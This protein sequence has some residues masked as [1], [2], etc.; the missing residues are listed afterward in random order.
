MT[1]C[2]KFV[3]P[4]HSTKITG[5][6]WFGGGI[7]RV[8]DSQYSESKLYIQLSIGEQIHKILQ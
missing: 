3:A 7:F 1:Q 2:L 6:S 8:S 4:T 5:A